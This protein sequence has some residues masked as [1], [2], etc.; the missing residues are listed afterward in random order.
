MPRVVVAV[1]ILA[2]LAIGATLVFQGALESGAERT[3]NVNETWTPSAGSVTTLDDSNL[4]RAYYDRNVTVYDELGDEVERG[5]D[6][7]WFQTNGTVKAVS[8]GELDGDSSANITYGYDR[9]SED[10]QNM[11]ALLSELPTVLALA[12]PVV[13]VFL[14]FGVILQ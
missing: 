7:E 12:L 4:S 10:Q 9:A 3:D 6:Y 13:L 1:A 14:L 11:V 5:T 8:G 2:V